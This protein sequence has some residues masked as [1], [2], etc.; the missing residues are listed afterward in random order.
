MWLTNSP[1]ILKSPDLIYTFKDKETVKKMLEPS[2]QLKWLRNLIPEAERPRLRNA[3]S[4]ET[5]R[6]LVT[7]LGEPSLERKKSKT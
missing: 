3:A 5:S 7:A 4:A 6:S 2:K 1:F